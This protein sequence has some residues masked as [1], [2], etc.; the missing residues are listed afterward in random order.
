MR[1]TTAHLLPLAVLLF[2]GD[3]AVGDE[4]LRWALAEDGAAIYERTQ[5]SEWI[6]RDVRY[7]RRPPWHRPLNPP[8][9]FG[10]EL[11]AERQYVTAP[12]SSLRDLPMLL[13]FDLR[14]GRGGGRHRLELGASCPQ[15]F[16]QEP[17]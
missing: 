13:A 17:H 7:E 5:E 8:V 2:L 16:Q 4:A 3:T 15:K 9:L 12:I 14:W 10:G 1:R 11:D 6:P